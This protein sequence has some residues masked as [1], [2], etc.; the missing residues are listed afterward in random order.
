MM[1]RAK[2]FH[3]WLCRLICGTPRFEPVEIPFA[4]RE[5]SHNNANAAMEVQASVSRLKR[6]TDVFQAFAAQ[7]GGT[8]DVG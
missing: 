2:Q 8:G 7:L 5:A 4:I 3:C 6:E 1:A